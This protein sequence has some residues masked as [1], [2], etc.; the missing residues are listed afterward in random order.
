MSHVSSN[1]SQRVLE[2]VLKAAKK[3]G[4]QIARY[5]V[6]RDGKIVVLIGEPMVIEITTDSSKTDNDFGG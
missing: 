3:A 6:E 4:M 2:R 1:V 5:E